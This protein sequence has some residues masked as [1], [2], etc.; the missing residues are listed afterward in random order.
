MGD[1]ALRTGSILR[2]G[3]YIIMT[4]WEEEY[5]TRHAEGSECLH[6]CLHFTFDTL[7]YLQKHEASAVSC[8]NTSLQSRFSNLPLTLLS[9]I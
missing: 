2:Q 9:L 4:S 7:V 6:T 3:Q 8:A 5:D 1:T